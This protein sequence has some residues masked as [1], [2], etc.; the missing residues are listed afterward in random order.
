VPGV[1]TYGFYDGWTPNYMFFI[2]HG[3]NATGR[4]YEVYSYCCGPRTQT[5]NQ[6]REWYRPNP[7]VG[8]V[9]WSP[10]ANTNIQQSGV[11]FSLNTVAKDREMYLDNY[12]RKNQRA[13][14]KGTDGPTFGWVIP[15]GQRR[16]ADAAQLVCCSALSSSGKPDTR[17]ARR[18]GILPLPVTSGK[19]PASA[20]R[21][22]SP[23]P[24]AWRF[25]PVSS[26]AA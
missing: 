1:W 2:A 7:I 17:W 5:F 24:L 13:V 20:A 25:S 19:T 8:Q 12:W 26:S 22:G 9:T 4:F 18:A 15:A 16:K 3:K 10:R 14:A 23:L 11:L 6:S 21:A